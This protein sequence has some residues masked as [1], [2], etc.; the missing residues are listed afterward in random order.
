MA[1]EKKEPEG[2]AKAEEAAPSGKKK[3]LIFIAVGILV[4]LL[5]GGGGTYVFVI[6]PK[7]AAQEAAAPVKKT[8]A[9]VDVR[10]MMVN[11]ANEPNQERPKLLKLKVSL[12]I[13]DPKQLPLIQPLL[14]RVEDAFQVLVRE[15]RASDLEGSAGVHRLREELLR[16]VN[17]AVYPSK[18]DA[19]LFK[20]FVV[21]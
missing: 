1:S 16:R 7:Q 15:M 20:D 21:Q 18:V 2:E 8:I 11:L 10:E 17:V 19:V 4:L 14:P 13:S 6:K 9:F 3:T 12:E 5:A